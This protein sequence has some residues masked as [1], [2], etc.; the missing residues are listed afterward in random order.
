V[1]AAFPDTFR[2]LSEQRKTGI[3]L[4]SVR[5]RLNC[6]YTGRP[7]IAKSARVS[8]IITVLICSTQ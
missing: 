2:I 6:P 8:E 5:E 1:L 4:V 3:E 7:V